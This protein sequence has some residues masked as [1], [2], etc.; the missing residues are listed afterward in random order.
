MDLEFKTCTLFV[1]SIF[2]LYI[3]ASVYFLF[4]YIFGVYFLI[5]FFLMMVIIF[6]R[7][8]KDKY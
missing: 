3:G 6:Y 2:I 5:P 4:I 8:Y 7:P 1:V